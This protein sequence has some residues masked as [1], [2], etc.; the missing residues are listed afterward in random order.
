MQ[1]NNRVHTS[2][3][4][5]CAHKTGRVC[6]HVFEIFHTHVCWFSQEHKRAQHLVMSWHW[7]LLDTFQ[8]LGESWGVWKGVVLC[9][10][11][12]KSQTEPLEDVEV[13]LADADQTESVWEDLLTNNKHLLRVFCPL[14]VYPDTAVLDHLIAAHNNRTKGTDAMQNKFRYFSALRVKLWE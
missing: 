7:P 14:V 10:D 1:L 11:V 2:K 6:S 13:S 3:R 8:W 5:I 9:A 4:V 12:V